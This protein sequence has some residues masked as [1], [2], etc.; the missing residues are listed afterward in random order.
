MEFQNLLEFE[1][2]NSSNIPFILEQYISFKSKYKDFIILYRVG[3]FYETYFEDALEFSKIC[4]ILLTKRKFKAGE[5]PMAGVPHKTAENYIEKLIKN[6]KKIVVVEQTEDKDENGRLIRKVSKIYTEGCLVESKFLDANENNFL[7]SVYKKGDIYEF[8][9]TDVSVGEIFRTCGNLNEIKCELT[10]ISPK[11]LLIPKDTKLEA[12]IYKNY[13]TEKLN[14]SFY[15]GQEENKAALAILNYAKFVLREFIPKFEEIKD[16]KIQ[17]H[18][19]LDFMTRKNLE[20]TKN[21]YNNKK[22]GSLFWALDYTKT[23]MG[24]RLLSLL[25]S[26]P[27]YNLAEIEKRQEA[28]ETLLKNKKARKKLDEILSN[29][30]DVLRISSRMSN[31]TIS[32]IE[33][34]ILKE[35]L[36][37]LNEIE[38]IKKELKSGWL[39]ENNEDENLLEDFYDILDRTLSDN[40]D[41]I[42]SGNYF[43]NG[44]NT[45]LDL[46]SDEL[47]CH[48]NEIKQYETTLR[49]NSKEA[50]LSIIKK[51]G[52]YY[53]EAKSKKPPYESDLRVVQNLKNSTRYTTNRLILLEEKIMALENKIDEK[54]AYIFENLRKYSKEL[55]EDIRKYS[56]TVAVLDVL[57]SLAHVIEKNNLTKPEIK[58]NSNI[59]IKNLRHLPAEKILNSFEPL[60]L[61]FEKSYF[62]ILTG[63][64][65]SGKS[66]LLKALASIIILAQSGFYVPAQSAKLPLVDKLFTCLSVSD[67]FVNKKSTHQMQMNKVAYILRE[68]TDDSVI[69][70]D[71]IGK[72][73]F[74]KDGIS[75]FY[76]ITKYLT[77]KSKAKTI[78]TTHFLD[79]KNLF[80]DME[81]KVSF[82]KIDNSKN[83]RELVFGITDTSSGI[84]AAKNEGVFNE[85]I[86]N[87]KKCYSVL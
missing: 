8:A 54:K 19:L 52:S 36:K 42:K 50:S 84:E 61:G 83:Q 69:L 58:N 65:G 15:E 77:E 73:T 81:D 43:K 37:V 44:A 87:S 25:I 3:D 16:Y 4:D 62:I 29:I 27:L 5:I 40:I 6:G 68:M 21:S 41:D 18:L 48:L 26:S 20:I 17:T 28:I 74:Y 72:H 66:T 80:F 70:L 12:D 13:K 1:K 57:C 38:K 53:I 71:E 45:E 86:E 51:G 30:K 10:R 24:K 32:P 7:S 46:L 34:F 79:L 56:K 64:N 47:N 82:M 2:N 11:E 14:K 75:L 63:K 22:E 33:F 85:I 9:Y 49:E 35:S 76:A 55:T 78:L 59:T 39:K 23:P 67:E 60:N 31:L